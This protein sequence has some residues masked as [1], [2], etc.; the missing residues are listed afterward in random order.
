MEDNSFRLIIFDGVE[1]GFFPQT[2]ILYE[3]GIGISTSKNREWKVRLKKDQRETNQITLGRKGWDSISNKYHRVLK[4]EA[5][6]GG[7][8]KFVRLWKYFIFCW[9]IPLKITAMLCPAKTKEL[10]EREQEFYN[11]IVRIS[12]G[13]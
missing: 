1:F 4:Q 13:V 8:S 9:A 6:S 2:V 3:Y 10:M 12:N 7:E 11:R 5:K